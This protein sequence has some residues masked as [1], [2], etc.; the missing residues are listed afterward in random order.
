MCWLN[1]INQELFW[2]P[3]AFFA[4]FYT[5]TKQIPDRKEKQGSTVTGN[6]QC[7][8]PTLYKHFAK[9]AKS[10]NTKWWWGW[11]CQPTISNGLDTFWLP[12]GKGEFS[13]FPFSWHLWLLNEWSNSFIQFDWSH[14]RK[15]LKCSKWPTSLLV[16]TEYLKKQTISS[17]SP[18]QLRHLQCTKGW[19]QNELKLC[20]NGKKE[21]PK[22]V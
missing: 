17:F 9:C 18:S 4:D 5:W 20:I 13:F 16:K 14:N 1:K 11:W 10:E 2:R 12:F 8:L 3:P 6:H 21:I 22:S 15:Q 7:L 19:C